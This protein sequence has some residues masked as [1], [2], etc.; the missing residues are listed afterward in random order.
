MAQRASWG[1]DLT[2]PIN[3]NKAR[4]ARA[5]ARKEQLARE[6]R[7]KHGR[8]RAQKARDTLEASRKRALLDDRKRD[9]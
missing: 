6:N 7:A 5:R 9:K 3:L 4:K 1:V 2:A 8:T